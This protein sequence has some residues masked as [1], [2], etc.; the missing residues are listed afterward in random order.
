LQPLMHQMLEMEVQDK[1]VRARRARNQAGLSAH[2]DRFN[3]GGER[4][5]ESAR[6]VFEFPA[7]LM[8]IVGLVL[9]IACANVAKSSDRARNAPS[10]GDRRQA[11]TR[12]E[13]RADRPRNSWSRACCSSIAGGLAGLC[14]PCG[15]TRPLVSFLPAGHQN[16]DHFGD[17]RLARLRLHHRNLSR[18]RTSFS[19]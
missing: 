8:A 17:A 1:G 7:V 16:T 13:P 9:L 3:S 2:V 6:S 12:R 14:W 15:S 4:P 10:E 18:D 11:G 19:A 5:V